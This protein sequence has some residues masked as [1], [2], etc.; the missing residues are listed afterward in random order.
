MDFP[1]WAGRQLLAEALDACG[2][3]FVPWAC[4]RRPRDTISGFQERMHAIALSGRVL[5]EARR[6]LPPGVSGAVLDR[7]WRDM[8][9]R[10]IVAGLVIGSPAEAA[11]SV[12]RDKPAPATPA[13]P[14][15]IRRRAPVNT[16]RP[17]SA[18]TKAPIFRR[19]G[20]VAHA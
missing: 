2:L 11:P 10:C 17:A 20:E 7:E 6:R 16:A 5:A 1:D 3:P 13:E 14:V 12:D 8:A 4:W 15:V 9:W 18:P 19:R